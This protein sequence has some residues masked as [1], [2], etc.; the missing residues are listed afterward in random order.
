VSY[1]LELR[2]EVK[3]DLKALDKTVASRILKKVQWLSE[4]GDHVI[5]LPLAANLAGFCKLRVG[6]Y[7]AIYKLEP[8]NKIVVYFVGHRRD[9]YKRLE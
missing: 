2:P 5:H 1:T 4:Q 8:E 3:D 9:I 6:D 7:R